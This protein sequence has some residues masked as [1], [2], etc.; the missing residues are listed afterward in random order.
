MTEPRTL[1]RGT[2]TFL[3]TDIEGS[4]TLER[5]IGRD[6][7]AELLARHRTIAREAWAAN[8]GHELGTE[9]DSFFVYFQESW[10][11][12]AAAG[13]GPP[14]PRGEPGAGRPTVPP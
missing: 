6:R 9:G 13:A 12:I 8:G 11:A 14:A 10:Q 5:T 4:T 2:L 1:P 3:F 7:Y